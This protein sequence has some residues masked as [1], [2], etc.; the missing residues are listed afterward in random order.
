M[1]RRLTIIGVVALVL[2]SA[3]A[4]PVAGSSGDDVTYED[5]TL[6]VAL[7]ED[8][9]ATVSLVSVY[10]LSDA[11]E[12]DA[13]ESLREDERVQDEMLERFADR[14]D[15]IATDVDEEMSVTEESV[16]VRTD[17][18]RGVVVL[19][20]AW[21][22][23]ASVDGET[24]VVTEPFASGF[25]PDRTL[26]VTAPGG[27]TIESTTPKP[28]TVDE[29]R[30]T[31]D[32]GTDLSGFETAVS[33]ADDED[34]TTDVDDDDSTGEDDA[35]SGFGVGIAVVGVVLSVAALLEART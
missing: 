22:G 29:T 25:E 16:D 31:W 14:A 3:L 6:H 35:T 20:V 7:T 24:L 26:V 30:A 18:D 28:A 9:D 2:A 13:F 17:D 27:A 8:G 33:L 34:R 21:N 4:V 5:P 1:D 23:L 32:A 15:S 12:R 19:S 11:N 10:D